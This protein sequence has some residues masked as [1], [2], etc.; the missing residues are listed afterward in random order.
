VDIR[1]F[2]TSFV[3]HQGG[4]P[5]HKGDG[6]TFALTGNPDQPAGTAGGGLGYA[7]LTDSVAIKFDLVDNAGEGVNSVGLYTGGADPTAGA[8]RLDGTPIN[9]Q[10]GDPF[11][12]D[13]AYD[14]TVLTLT[15]TD[16]TAPDQPWTHQ[17]PVNVPAAVGSPTGYVG[18]TA[19]TG[20]LLAEQSID[21]WTFASD[22]PPSRP[23]VISDP[24]GVA[25]VSLLS[26]A[27]IVGATDD[28]GPANLTYTWEIVS[29]PPG[30]TSHISPR[31]GDPTAAIAGFDLPGHYQFRVTVRDANGQTA[32]SEVGYNFPTFIGIL[33]VSPASATLP[34]GG[35]VRFTAVA[36]NQFHLAVPG[37]A[38]SWQVVSGPGTIDPFGRYTAPADATGTATVRAAFDG[39]VTEATVTI[40][41][42]VGIAFG[43]GFDGVDLARNGPARVAGDRLRLADDL[44]QAGSAYAPSP[45]DVRGFSTSFRFQ[46]GDAPSWWLGDG[47]T[48][49][50][51]NAGSDAVGVAGGGL[52]YTGIGRSVAV[53]FDLVDNAGEGTDSVGVYTGGADPTTP[54][55]RLPAGMHL[56][57]GNVFRVGLTYAAGVLHLELQDTVTGASFARSYAVDIAGAVGGPTAYAGFTAGTGSLSAPIEV[58]DWTYTPAANS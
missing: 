8:V 55:D 37:L 31:P 44:F 57:S 42:A 1:A 30:A 45:V 58:L 48:F 6:F 51:Q 35:M 25:P 36:R 23:P 13:L 49:V 32:V 7:G 38:A 21:S 26:V 9:L 11:R 5:A 50:L 16:M 54:A 22:T 20:A 4:E 18:F 12:A 39:T 15:L 34:A 14:G 47:L 10:S 33:D 24:A 3:F 2:H 46:V 52:G 28:G 53:K 43:D 40:T 41:P 17:F 19:G 29:A 56:N 27:L